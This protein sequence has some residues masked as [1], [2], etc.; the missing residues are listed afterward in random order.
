MKKNR[1]SLREKLMVL[2]NGEGNANPFTGRKTEHIYLKKFQRRIS[3][4]WSSLLCIYAKHNFSVAK[5]IEY[6]IPNDISKYLRK[7]DSSYSG[8]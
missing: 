3:I 2:K 8:T 7:P 6:I 5:N 4:L 1:G